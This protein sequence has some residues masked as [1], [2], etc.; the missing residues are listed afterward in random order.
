MN[1]KFYLCLSVA[2]FLSL[3]N[4]CLLH[5]K[6]NRKEF[7]LALAKKNNREKIE[8]TI[9]FSSV[10]IEF[11]IIDCPSVTKV[12]FRNSLLGR[13]TVFYPISMSI[14]FQFH[15]LSKALLQWFIVYVKQLMTDII[16][17]I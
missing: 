14:Q 10:F 5:I 3:V 1:V 13:C 8:F 12:E 6:I 15:F 4:V 7:S 9:S 16:T 11:K 2:D 17:R